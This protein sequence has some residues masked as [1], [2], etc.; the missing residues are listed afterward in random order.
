MDGVGKS[1]RDKLQ[2][3][4]TKADR[5]GGKPATTQTKKMPLRHGRHIT[6]IAFV[7]AIGVT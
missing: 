2:A 3:K 4:I 6:A 5:R 7:A 1:I